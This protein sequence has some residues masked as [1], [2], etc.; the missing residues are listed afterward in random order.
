M[1]AKILI[2]LAVCLQLA[3]TNALADFPC[4][5]PFHYLGPN[6]GGGYDYYAWRH[7]ADCVD[8]TF[9]SFNYDDP[10][11]VMFCP[12]CLPANAESENDAATDKKDEGTEKNAAK[13]AADP[14]TRNSTYLDSLRFTNNTFDRDRINPFGQPLKYRVNTACEGE[15]PRYKGV[16]IFY[17]T[18]EFSD[19]ET[20]VSQAHEIE[21]N[22]DDP[23]LDAAVLN[24]APVNQKGNKVLANDRVELQF[25]NQRCVCFL[26]S[27]ISEW[28]CK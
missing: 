21:A 3:P 2:L 25:G 26:T 9:I 12:N 19:D 16:I 23:I 7:E 22:E 17:M 10:N 24:W 11:V 27:E 1:K 8:K 28:K 15:D 4:I 14:P 5:C 20:L 13:D 6:P 18:I